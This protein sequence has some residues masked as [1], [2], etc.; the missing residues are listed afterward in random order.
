MVR[1]I[2][3]RLKN[4]IANRVRQN[5]T[6]S[7]LLFSLAISLVGS[8]AF[9]SGNN[10][11]FLLLASM[12]AILLVSG[13]INRLSLAGL[14]LDIT[15]PEHIS[16]RRAISSRMRLRNEK[17]WIPSFSIEVAGAPGSV[18]SAAIYF[19]VLPGRQTVEEMVEVRFHRRGPHSENSFYL[20]SR[21]PFGFAERNVR[22]GMRRELLV[23][24]CLDPQPG[25]DGILKRL[26]GELEAYARG[27]GHDFYRIRPYEPQESARHVDWKATAHTGQ[28]QVREFARDEEPLVEMLLDLS[29]PDKEQAWFE[30]AVDC[31]AFLC[32][33]LNSTGARIRFRTQ[34]WDMQIPSEGNIYTILKYL[35]LVAPGR[36]KAVSGPGRED[37]FQIVFS[38]NARQVIA[39]GWNSSHV[40]GLDSFPATG[41]NAAGQPETGT[42]P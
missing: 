22:V 31:C 3:S 33:R 34:D 37:S 14:E 25:F 17:G 9:L 26:S 10:L 11:L 24:P 39:A 21:F 20:R 42:G 36:Y 38:A 19:P 13:F 1:A 23:Y 5:I 32:W 29:V 8:A 41:A 6:R 30:K 28:L 35:A 18:Y 16:A 27:H 40:F 4:A 15:L 7:G 2:Y 12:I